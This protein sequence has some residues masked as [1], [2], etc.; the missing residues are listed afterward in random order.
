MRKTKKEKRRNF[1][2]YGWY[3]C[4]AC[5]RSSCRIVV[6]YNTQLSLS[7][8]LSLR[9]LSPIHP[10]SLSLS[11]S[12]SLAVLLCYYKKSNSKNMQ[13]KVQMT[14]IYSSS[15]ERKR[16]SLFTTQTF[17]C[18]AL[19][20][21]AFLFNA[22]TLWAISAQYFLL[23]INKRSKSLTFLTTNFKKPFGKTCLAFLAVP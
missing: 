2:N 10:S 17:N 4:G 19:S 1:Q 5:D 16:A 21:I 3:L 18:A 9:L 8:S 23:C 20:T 6:H 11:L 15:S 7:L 12:L 13:T 22:E 14:H